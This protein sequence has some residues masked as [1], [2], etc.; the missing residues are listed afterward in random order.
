MH[1]SRLFEHLRATGSGLVQWLNTAAS[2]ITQR[3]GV[4]PAHAHEMA[5]KLL[6]EASARQAATLA[7]A[8]AFL[9]MAGIGFAALCLVPLMSPTPVVKK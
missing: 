7:Y 3:G 9:F 1:S 8:D 4:S 2:T 6:G 5:L